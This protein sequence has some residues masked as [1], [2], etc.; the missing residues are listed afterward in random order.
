MAWKLA[1]KPTKAMSVSTRAA[2]PTP[3]TLMNPLANGALSVAKLLAPTTPVLRVS[4]STE[5]NKQCNHAED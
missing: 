1:I 3:N 2:S 4:V 5:K